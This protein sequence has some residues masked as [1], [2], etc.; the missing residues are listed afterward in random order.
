MA[1]GDAMDASSSEFGAPNRRSFRQPVRKSKPEVAGRWACAVL[2]PDRNY[3][4]RAWNATWL[5]EPNICESAVSSRKCI[6]TPPISSRSIKVTRAGFIQIVLLRIVSFRN[7][8][9][10]LSTSQSGD[11]EAWA[12][13]LAALPHEAEHNASITLCP[14]LCRNIFPVYPK[15]RPGP[16][17]LVYIVFPAKRKIRSVNASNNQGRHEYWRGRSNGGVA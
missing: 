15:K 11:P 8:T 9:C 14:Q 6:L 5:G 13:L 12:S 3:P 10:S 2:H 4:P 7:C 16:E 17:E 1:R